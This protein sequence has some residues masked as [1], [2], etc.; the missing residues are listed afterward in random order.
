MSF[1]LNIISSPSSVPDEKELIAALFRSGLKYFHL[2]KP[3]M[4]AKKM[5]SFVS[6]V[7]K[8]YHSRMIIHSHYSLAKKYD[9]GGIHLSEKE[10]NKNSER[11]NGK[12]ISTGFHF[13]FDVLCFASYD[14]VFLSPVFDSISKR[15]YKGAIVLNKI[16]ILIRNFKAQKGH[17][18]ALIALGGISEKN[19]LKVRN[20]GF[21]GAAFLGAIWLSKDPVKSFSKIRSKIS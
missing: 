1:K 10:R 9:L 11:F 8:K 19:I 14:S 12:F 7:P 5:N 20:A 2:R 18:P 13:P 4:S 21:D 3:G 17:K 15:G 6:A 16:K